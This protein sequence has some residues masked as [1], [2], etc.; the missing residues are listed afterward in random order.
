[1]GFPARRSTAT[2]RAG[3]PEPDDR[4]AG[5]PARSLRYRLLAIALLPM[6]VILP[7][8][9]DVTICRW[10]AKFDAALISKVNGDLTIAH[11]FL[12]RIL[13][14]TGLHIIALGGSARFRD[15]VAEGRPALVQLLGDSR[16]K[17]DLDFLYIVSP[18]GNLQASSSAEAG[19]QLRIDWPIIRA[20]IH[21]RPATAIDILSPEDLQRLSPAFA[22]RARLA[23]VATPNAMPTDKSEE[24]VAWWCGARALFRSLMEVAPFWSAGRCSIKIFSSSARST[25]SSIARQASRKAARAR[26]R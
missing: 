14:N 16:K 24:H 11:Q 13:D 3:L 2:W 23:L 8:L 22:E 5:P 4:G 6:L 19:A 21:G 10:D 7:L 18:D 25:I 1:M 9:L 15:V 12:A 17:L 26:R 20:A